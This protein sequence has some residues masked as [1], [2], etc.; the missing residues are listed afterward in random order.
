MKT[1]HLLFSAVQ[2]LFT[3]LILLVGGFFIGLYYAPHLRFTIG[4]FFIEH[5][6]IFIAIGLS[7]LGCGIL[8]LLGFYA[9]NRGAYFRFAIPA[10]SALIEASVVRSYV[11]KYWAGQF[12]DS[13]LQTDVLLHSNQKM[14]ISLEMPPLKTQEHQAFLDKVEKDLR[15]LLSHSLGYDGDFLLTII[16]K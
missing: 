2:F 15:H 11:N 6:E 16:V 4:Q 8:L 9:M 1:S 14:E 5:G 10:K 13:E 7:V 3:V 12:P